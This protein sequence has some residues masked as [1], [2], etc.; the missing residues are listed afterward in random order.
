[1]SRVV[2]EPFM[3]V[4]ID[5]LVE[6]LSLCFSAIRTE[7]SIFAQ[8]GAADD[9][10]ASR[11]A[12]SQAEAAAREL[13]AHEPSRA[14]LDHETKLE[15]RAPTHLPRQQ[16]QQQ[17]EPAEHTSSPSAKPQ[18]GSQARQASSL[19]IDEAPPLGAGAKR[20]ETPRRKRPP[21]GFRPLLPMREN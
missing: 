15:I 20:Q 21:R 12:R 4:D 18:D 6:L 13:P 17:Q 5:F 8:S 10:W 11:E 3:K 14:E 1:M 7:K 19:D 2:K 9:P 16:Q